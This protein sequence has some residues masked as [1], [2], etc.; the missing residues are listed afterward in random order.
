LRIG[1]R[2][3]PPT[4][5]DSEAIKAKEL[6]VRRQVALTVSPAEATTSA[7]GSLTSGGDHISPTSGSDHLCTD[8]QRLHQRARR[9]L[10]SRPHYGSEDKTIQECRPPRRTT[11]CTTSRYDRWRGRSRGC[12]QPAHGATVA[13]TVDEQPRSV[14]ATGGSAG[15]G[16]RT[17]QAREP[18]TRQLMAPQT[19][20]PAYPKFASSAKPANTLLPRMLEEEVDRQPTRKAKLPL[21]SP[22]SPARMMN[23]LEAEGRGRSQPGSLLSTTRLV[24]ILMDDHRPEIATGLY[25]EN[26]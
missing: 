20:Y 16:T 19:A 10:R 18:D 6:E 7:S 3:R 2:P 9:G 5:G 15:G 4:G 11:S 21:G 25:D 12:G 17:T 23:I 13:R 14:P 26:P 22:S 1:P 8:G 24:V